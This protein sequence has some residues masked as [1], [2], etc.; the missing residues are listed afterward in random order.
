MFITLNYYINYKII[1]LLF[2]ILI[3]YCLICIILN[4]QIIKLL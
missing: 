3:I 4:Y 2:I 1:K